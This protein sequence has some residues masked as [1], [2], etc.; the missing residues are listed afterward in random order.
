MNV[1]FIPLLQSVTETFDNLIESSFSVWQINNKTYIFIIIIFLLLNIYTLNT[2][3]IL[4]K[5]I[6]IK[7]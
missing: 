1:D 2:I 6:R 5:E 7:L 4:L 3:F